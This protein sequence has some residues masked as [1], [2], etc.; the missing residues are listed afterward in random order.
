MEFKDNSITN[1]YYKLSSAVLD[2]GEEID[3]TFEIRNVT[4]VLTNPRSR[5][6]LE[7]NRKHS[8]TYVRAELIWYLM[9]NNSITF[10]SDY[11]KFWNKVCDMNGFVNSNYGSKIFRK[12]YVKSQMQ[13]VIDELARNPYSRR[14]IMMYNLPIDYVKMHSTKDYPCTVVSQFFVR[15]N[16]LEHT[17]FMRSNDLFFGWCNDIPFFSFVQEM[18]AVSLNLKM[19]NLTHIAG[20]LH[21]YKNKLDKFTSQSYNRDNILNKKEECVFPH[22]VN[23]DIACLMNIKRVATSR[24]RELPEFTEFLVN[25][26]LKNKVK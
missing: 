9:K 2:H 17:V 14:A 6:I 18:I 13:F 25:G 21:I 15:N 10:I 7:P 23:K 4:N 26:I 8:L 1:L 22:M 24:S 3:N 20:S 11:S 19:G 12:I 16:K 5:Y